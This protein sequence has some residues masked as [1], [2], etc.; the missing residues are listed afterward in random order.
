[1]VAEVLSDIAVLV[2]T[3][4]I[5]IVGVANIFSENVA[6]NSTYDELISLSES[7]LV[8][9][10]VACDGHVPHCGCWV[11]VSGEAEAKSL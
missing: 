7:L 11:L 8:N 6:V 1:M 5:D 3:P 4:E 10:N 2:T 9:V